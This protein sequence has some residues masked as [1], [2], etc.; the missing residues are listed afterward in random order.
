MATYPRE[1]Q[2]GPWAAFQLSGSR[3]HAAGE[4]V[5][6]LLNDW[7]NRPGPRRPL[8]SSRS[9]SVSFSSRKE[10]PTRWPQ[11]AGISPSCKK[12]EAVEWP[13]I[14]DIPW[15]L[16]RLWQRNV[17]DREGVSPFLTGK[18]LFIPRPGGILFGAA[19]RYHGA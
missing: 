6:P 18:F 8:I 4:G 5:V 7:L 17:R 13:R 16:S 9:M 19:L 15:A 1:A 14:G 11:P 10:S 3:D 12:N 2:P